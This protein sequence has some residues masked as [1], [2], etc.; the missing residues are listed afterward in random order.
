MYGSCVF[1][2]G[3]ILNLDD[4]AQPSLLTHSLVHINSDNPYVT[5]GL[6]LLFCHIIQIILFFLYLVSGMS[7]YNY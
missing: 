6:L 5:I 7:P 3:D 4:N 1:H 2:Q